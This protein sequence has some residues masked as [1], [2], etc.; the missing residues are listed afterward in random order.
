MPARLPRSYLLVPAANPAM[1]AK[2]ARSAADAVCIDL[3]DAVAPDQKEASRAHVVQALREL[4]WGPRLRL[5]RVNGLDTPF[6]YRDLIEVVEATGDRLDLI[7]VPKVNRPEDVAFVD[8][9]LTQIELRQGFSQRIGIEAQIETALGCVNAAAIAASS[10][11]LDALIFGMGDYAAS[12]R[13]PLDS[14]G[15]PDDND[16]R[17]PGHRWHY[18]MSQLVN[19]A[20]AYDKRAIDGPFAGLRDPEGF[21]AACETARAL[22]FDGKW[23]IHP[24]QLAAT[25]ELFAPPAAQI[26]WARTVLDEYARATAEGRGALAV[27]DKMIDAASLRMARMIVERVDAA[28]A[29]E[30]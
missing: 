24:S 25:N 5:Y 30:T 10:S 1:I 21:R 2:A 16:R 23:C 18:V 11:R 3:E 17:Y 15:E 26:A 20:R 9:L 22:G 6:A 19:A 29:R 12:V 13:M 4:D 27:Q 8:T 7:I 14:I 28:R